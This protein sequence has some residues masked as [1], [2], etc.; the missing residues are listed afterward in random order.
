VLHISLY[1]VPDDDISSL[2][3]V[4]TAIYS[5]LT[6]WIYNKCIQGQLEFCECCAVC[7]G[8]SPLTYR[9]CV[10]AE[11]DLGIGR[12]LYFTCRPTVCPQLPPAMCQPRQPGGS[13]GVVLNPGGRQVKGNSGKL[14]ERS[15]T[16][17]SFRADRLSTTQSSGGLLLDNDL[18]AVITGLGSPLSAEA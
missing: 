3:V 7:D 5:L 14:R 12:Q 11:P 10:K 2:S 9:M 4:L 18:K 16:A 6:P 13:P 1:T 17:P 15:A 8:S